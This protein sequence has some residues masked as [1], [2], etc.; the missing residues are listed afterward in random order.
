MAR[1]AAL[2]KEKRYFNM[3]YEEQKRLFGGFKLWD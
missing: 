3:P 1:I 2:D